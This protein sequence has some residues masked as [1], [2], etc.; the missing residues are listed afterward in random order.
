MSTVWHKSMAFSLNRLARFVL[1]SGYFLKKHQPLIQTT[2]PISLFFPFQAI[3][4]NFIQ[5]SVS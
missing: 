1:Y 2:I 4:P 3:S 5:G